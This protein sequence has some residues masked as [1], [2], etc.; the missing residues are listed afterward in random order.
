MRQE[1]TSGEKHFHIVTNK[2]NNGF[3]W[4][5]VGS[6]LYEASHIIHAMFLLYLLGPSYYGLIGSMFSIIYLIISVVDLGFEVSFAPFLPLISQ[7]KAS[8]K[9]VIPVYLC[10]QIALLAIGSSIFFIYYQSLL[11]HERQPL[12]FLFFF[13]LIL[14]EG[15]R[16]FCRRFLH[17][18]FLSKTTVLVEQ[19]FAFTYYATI[20]GLF[21]AGVQLSLP[22]L[23]IP[24]FLNS[25]FVVLIFLLMLTSFY[26]KLPTNDLS[27]PDNFW[28]RLIKTRYYNALINI[29]NFL[30]S[31]NFFVPFFAITFGLYQAGLFKIASITAHA[32]KAIVKSVVHFPGGAFLISLK[33][34][35]QA[36]K[37]K[38]FYTLA[39]KLNQIILFIALFLLINHRAIIR[40]HPVSPLFQS[41]W[42][43]A[44]IFIG[45][46]L[47]HQF[48]IV[49]EEF[50]II[51]ELA[52]KLFFIKSI[53]LILFGF[54]IM[55]NKHLTP[56]TILINVGLIQLFCFSL[57]ALHAY[58]QWKIKPYFKV[59]LRFFGASLLFALAAFFILNALPNLH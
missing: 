7:N 36:I 49:Y 4:S 35:S 5:L 34:Q 42:L 25:F 39:E 58:T 14:L 57:L 37:T 3:K 10:F 19:A 51:E 6:I 52:N 48:F 9:R 32:I 46:T 41:A 1:G 8:F 59:K 44:F 53:E 43:Y 12:P 26:K 56:V 31:G 47:L 20:W 40:L 15:V 50:Y 38:A 33:N 11:Y 22:L 13:I 18:I 23:F 17:N 21:F 16:I 28:K 55:A 54:V 29:E 30:I 24:Y 27:L 2:F 45:I